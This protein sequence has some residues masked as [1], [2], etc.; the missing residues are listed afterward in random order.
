MHTT[1]LFC[2]L[3]SIGT[4]LTEKGVNQDFVDTKVPLL[5]EDEMADGLLPGVQAQAPDA[6]PPLSTNPTSAP[7]PNATASAPLMHQA[8]MAEIIAPPAPLP[9]PTP[10]ATPAQTPA[11]GSPFGAPIPAPDPFSGVSVALVRKGLQVLSATWSR[12]TLLGSLVSVWA[13]SQDIALA[14]ICLLHASDDDYLADD[15][16]R[17]D[18]GGLAKQW[19]DAFVIELC[20]PSQDQVPPH[21]M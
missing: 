20:V 17:D 9:A 16:W 12:D 13:E 10:A 2:S 11:V 8:S 18:L 21:S 4:A 6:A 15:V 5:Q 19:G 7:H 14:R 3:T 1:A